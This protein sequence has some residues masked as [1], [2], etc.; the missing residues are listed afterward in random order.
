MKFFNKLKQY[1]FKR[2]I[3]SNKDY[4]VSVKITTI[5]E[6][7]NPKIEIYYRDGYEDNMAHFMFKL[8]E[9][10]FLDDIVNQLAK[11]YSMQ[12]TNILSEHFQQLKNSKKELED[13]FLLDA[14]PVKE[15]PFISP[16]QV[17]NTGGPLHTQSNN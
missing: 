12:K 3:N 5:E 17:F 8:S 16:I 14:T 13:L 9:G 15:L 11:Q 6:N 7:D 4:I 2:F 1:F 10:L